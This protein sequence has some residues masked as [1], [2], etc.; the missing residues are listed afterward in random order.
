M[1]KQPFVVLNCTQ[2]GLS[3]AKYLTLPIRKC[4]VYPSND[5]NAYG[6]TARLDR[7]HQ[8]V[9][10]I[11]VS[12]QHLHLEHP[13]GYLQSYFICPLLPPKIIS[14]KA[15]SILLQYIHV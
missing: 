2:V 11:F 7:S 12:W 5:S 1:Q 6:H 4:A 8:S 14:T 10:N 3:T 13:L 9:Y 15:S